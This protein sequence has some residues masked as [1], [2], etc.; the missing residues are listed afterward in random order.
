VVQ[1]NFAGPLA[2]S[3]QQPGETVAVTR[4]QS[5]ISYGKDIGVDWRLLVKLNNLRPPY[6]VF[7]GQVLKLK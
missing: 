4:A 1:R 5:L 2:P 7:P 6:L 3:D